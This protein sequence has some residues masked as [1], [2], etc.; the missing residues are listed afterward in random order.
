MSWNYLL[1]WQG[2]QNLELASRLHVL[3]QSTAL[4]GMDDEAWAANSWNKSKVE[5]TRAQIKKVKRETRNWETF[6]VQTE[7]LKWGHELG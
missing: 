7:G 4:E 3:V 6:R 5:W 1:E 2:H